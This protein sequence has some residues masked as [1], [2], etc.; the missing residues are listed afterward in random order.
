LGVSHVG[1]QVKDTR[2]A[3]KVATQN[4]AKG[5]LEPYEVVDKDGKGKVIIAEI[6]LYSDFSSSDPLHASET[7]IRFIQY[8]DFEG[9]F[10]P[11]YRKVKDPHALD[12]GLLRMDHVVGNVYNMD[13]IINQLKKWTGLHTFAKFSKEEIQT[14][15]TSLNSEVLA[16]SNERVLFPINESAPG[17][18]ESQ[19]TEYLKA[20]NGPGVQHIAI[21]T[22]NVLASVKAMRDNSESGF[23]FMS[24]PLSYYQSPA[25]SKLMKENLTE[26]E[27]DAVIE[28][29]ILIDKDDEGVLLQIFT[30]PL[31]DRA[32]I[33]IEI[34][35]RKCMG[36]TI[37][38]PGCGGFGKGNFK[39][40][41]E[42]IERLQEARGSFELLPKP[43]HV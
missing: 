29:G 7:V 35:Q 19:I 16:S 11:G 33:F 1:V 24:T 37:D 28:L 41:F 40:L 18:K 5:I 21:K 30:K 12:Y 32:T 39:A 20:Y 34:I 15:W 31:F 4:G 25:M 26:E 27:A 43:C 23:E 3:Y 38:I 36:Q 10:L 22:N 13:N 9:P 6:D 42:A 2:E 17:K 14:P 8:Q